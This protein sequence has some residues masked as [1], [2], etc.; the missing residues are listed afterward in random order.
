MLLDLP[1]VIAYSVPLFIAVGPPATEEIR[2]IRAEPDAF[3]KGYASCQHKSHGS[4]TQL[5][6]KPVSAFTKP[7]TH[8]RA[9]F[10]YGKLAWRH[11]T[12]CWHSVDGNM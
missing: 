6:N 3:S 2:I 5:I 12:R 11:K 4:I 9:Q 8:T 1:F 10:C 7:L